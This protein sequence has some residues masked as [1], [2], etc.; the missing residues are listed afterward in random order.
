MSQW[1]KAKA[2]LKKAEGFGSVLGLTTIQGLLERLGNPQDKLKIIHVAGTNGKGSTCAYLQKVLS[3]AGYRVGMYT[4]PAVFSF[5]ER[6]SV[7]GEYI[8]MEEYYVYVTEIQEVCEN[9][10]GDEE[11]FPTIF[12]IETVV[13][14]LYFLDK[15]CDPVIMEVGMGGATDATNVISGSLCSVFASIGRDHMQ[16]LGDSLANIAKVKAGIIKTDGTAIS[17]WQESSVAGALASEAKEKGATIRFARKEAVLLEGEHPFVISYKEFSHIEIGMEGR[18]QI[19]NC[20]LALETLL[21]LKHA[22]YHISKEAVREGIKKT[23]WPGRMEKISL[24]PTIYIDGAHNVPAAKR[25]KETL[26]N[27][28]TNK[29]I[30]FIIGVLA[31]KEH[32]E[33]LSLVL[34]FATD[35]IA[36]TPDNA[37]AMPEREL[38]DEIRSLGYPVYESRSFY[39]AVDNAVKRDN[40]M[41]LA[42]GSLSYLGDLKESVLQWKKEHE[43]V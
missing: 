37:R 8:S 39:D 17:I 36:V 32:K 40:D 14:F 41:I 10:A 30:T 16:F 22:G 4:S 13:A 42:F 38:V 28:F 26:E 33:M 12:E 3:K 1:E 27:D 15:G 2:F 18:Y 29:T 6:F 20:V 34:P 31:D 23:K 24:V 9:V 5:Q 35:V 19:D 21:Y 43:N 11:L 25:L 7:N